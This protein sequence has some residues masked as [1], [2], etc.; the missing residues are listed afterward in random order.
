M[1]LLGG[2]FMQQLTELELLEIYEQYFEKTDELKLKRFPSKQKKQHGVCLF[3]IKAIDRDQTYSE[4]EINEIL[5][6]IYEDY[7]M[8]R[9]YLVDLGLLNRTNDGSSYWV[10]P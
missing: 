1:R 7:V 8:I 3:I 9:R 6:P 10:N 5:K 4:K 2:V